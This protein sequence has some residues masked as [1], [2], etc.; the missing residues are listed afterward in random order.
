MRHAERALT[1]GRACGRVFGQRRVCQRDG[2]ATLV[3]EWLRKTATAAT[4]AA[5]PMSHAEHALSNGRACER[6]LTSVVFDNAT[7]TP[8]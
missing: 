4:T 8:L 2:D 7:A 5:A 1:F 3:S 6:D